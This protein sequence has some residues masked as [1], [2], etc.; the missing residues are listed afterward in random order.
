MKKFIISVALFISVYSAFGQDTLRRRFNAT[1]SFQSFVTTP[2]GRFKGT[3]TVND[4][5]NTYN[6]SN[7]QVGDIVFTNAFSQ[8]RVDSIT[9]TF[10]FLANV[11]LRRLS[12]PN[13]VPYG[14]GDISKGT[15]V[16]NLPTFTPDNANGISSQLQFTKFTNFAI[17]VDSLIAKAAVLGNAFR[18]YNKYAVSAGT[19]IPTDSTSA[20]ANNY[21]IITLYAS[22]GISASSN[23]QINFGT[24]TSANYGD[25][26]FIYAQDDNVTRNIILGGTLRSGTTDL[27]SYTLLNGQ[28]AILVCQQTNLGAQWVLYS[29]GTGTAISSAPQTK[30]IAKANTYSIPTKGY[31]PVSASGRPANTLAAD[32]LQVGFIVA[33]TTDSITIQ[34]SGIFRKTSHGL[35]VGKYYFLRDDGSESLTAATNFNSMTVYVIDANNLFFTETR[36][37]SLY[38]SNL[39]AT[40]QTNSVTVANTISETPLTSASLLTLPANYL[41]VGKNIRIKISGYL[42]T[43]GGPNLSVALKFGSIVAQTAG[44]Q[45]MAT[46]GTNQYWE[47]FM[48]VTVRSIG[49]SGTTFSQG[50]INYFTGTTTQNVFASATTSTVTI[51]TTISIPVSVTAQWGTANVLN[52]ITATNC[53]IEILN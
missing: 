44:T 28:T 22:L 43:T 29:T 12:G 53:T 41:T 42:T 11:T 19:D 6:A 48:D 21:N 26:F 50:R 24:P 35:T 18:T 17:K 47:A 13:A 33:R 52:S 3:M 16:Y 39:S 46:I 5:T 15:R 37:T 32:S 34:Y 25:V 20:W 31:I 38:G 2:T 7:I 49:S 51:N 10:L 23:F 45:V 30:I 27:S 4:Q 14:V 9:S 40:V 8:Y 1:V 36:P